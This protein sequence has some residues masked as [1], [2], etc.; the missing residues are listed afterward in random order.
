LLQDYRNLKHATISLTSR[1]RGGAPSVTH[2]SSYKQAVKSGT[3]APSKLKAEA[4][5]VKEPFGGAFIVE[6]C[7]KPPIVEFE[8]P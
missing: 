8:D 4:S 6:Q 7:T 3:S 2:P 1:L 5:K